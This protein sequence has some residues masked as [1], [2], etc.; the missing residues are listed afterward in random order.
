MAHSHHGGF[1]PPKKGK[2]KEELKRTWLFCGG[3]GKKYFEIKVSA[4]DRETAIAHFETDYPEL[5]W[6]MTKEL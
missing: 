3:H 4:E 1:N 5:K 6:V 2:N